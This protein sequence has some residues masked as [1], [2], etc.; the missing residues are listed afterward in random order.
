MRR[1]LGDAL[2]DAHAVLALLQVLVTNRGDGLEKRPQRRLDDVVQMPLDPS[3]QRRHLLL[4]NLDRRRL[5]ARVAP[6][7]V[8]PSLDA[9]REQQLDAC[10][11]ADLF[12]PE[13]GDLRHDPDDASRC[14]TEQVDRVFNPPGPHQRAAVH[15]H[16][17]GL[18][19]RLS[20]PLRERSL[21]HHR[22][23]A[24]EQHA[25]HLVRHHPLAEPLQRSL[26]ERRIVDV[27]AVQDHLPAPI[28]DRE[29]HRLRVRGAHVALE[30]EHHAEHRRRVRLVAGSG[31]PVHALELLLEG[32]VEELVPVQPEKTEQRPHAV[33]A[34]HDQLLL[35]RQLHRRLPTIHV[36]TSRRARDHSSV[37][38]SIPP[39]RKRSESLR[40]QADRRSS[41]VHRASAWGLRR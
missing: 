11:A 16:P 30:Q 18:R 10:L 12:L 22:R 40:Y 17:H 7:D 21:A 33:Q 34:L 28:H 15:R 6:V 27:E 41:R 25:V 5:L 8:E 20:L 2:A 4:D 39:A 35:L 9:R 13:L 37:N 14:V 19:Q 26:R 38:L 3:H 23:G 29:L 32:V 31:L 1:I 36:L 24:L